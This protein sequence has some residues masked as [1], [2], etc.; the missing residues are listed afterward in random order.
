MSRPSVLISGASIAGPALAYWLN[1]YG[2]HTTV[3]E[4]ATSLRCEGQNIDV[5]GAG[6][7]VARRMGIDDDIRAAG[8]GEQ[9][10]QFVNADGDVK[11]SFPAGTSD[12]DGATAELEILRGELARILVDRTN[13]DTE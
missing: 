6:R 5:R 1:R 10:T 12:T 3:I 7:E 13:D 4:R 9:G 2:W 11:A 8:T